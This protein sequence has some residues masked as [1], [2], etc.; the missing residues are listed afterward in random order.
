MLEPDGEAG[1]VEVDETFDDE[2]WLGGDALLDIVEELDNEEEVDAALLEAPAIDALEVEDTLEEVRG[3]L[4]L[5][6]VEDSSDC[7][8]MD[9]TTEAGALEATPPT[10]RA[11]P[12]G[13][14]PL[15]PGGG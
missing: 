5:N 4:V 2:E 8:I 9:D 6:R 13:T 14:S 1:S 7:C 11:S 12:N 15:I 3:V 10:T